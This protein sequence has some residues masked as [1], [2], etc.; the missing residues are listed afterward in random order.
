MKIL[1]HFLWVLLCATMSAHAAQL[2]RWVD[3]RG[4]VEWRDTPPPASAPAKKIEQRRMGDN[5][6]PSADVPYSVQ[7]AMKNHPVT[8]WATDCGALC[9]NAR[10]HLNRR[11]IP[12]TDKNPQ[13]DFEGFKKI[14]PDGSIPLLQ[15]GSTQ[16]KGYLESEWDSTLDYAGY[17]RTALATTRPKP[18]AA[19]PK[20]AVDGTKPAAEGA[21]P[22]ADGTKPA[23]PVAAVPPAPATPGA[24]TPPPAAPAK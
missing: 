2:Y 17:P 22:A 3:A 4:N 16:L 23:E 18:P 15:V 5:V 19:A 20:P 8:L 9:T 1:R 11:G 7:L 12:Y 21:K 24:A 10:A 13:S 6:T 14:S